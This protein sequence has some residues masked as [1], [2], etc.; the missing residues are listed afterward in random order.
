MLIFIIKSYDFLFF[1]NENEEYISEVHKMAFLDPYIKSLYYIRSES[2]VN[3]S[4]G[5]C[6]SCHG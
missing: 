5:E 2:G 1:I 6:L 3:V 4:K